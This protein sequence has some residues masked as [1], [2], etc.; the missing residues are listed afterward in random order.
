MNRLGRV[1]A[2]LVAPAVLILACGVDETPTPRPLPTVAERGEALS[3]AKRLE[4]LTYIR[5][6]AESR[7]FVGRGFLWGGIAEAETGLAHCNS[8]VS[9][10][11]P[12]P[13]SADCGGGAVLAGGADGPCG[14]QQG[15]LGMFQFDAGTYAQTVAA[16]SND[17]LTVKGNVGH[18][19]DFV[20]GIV[21]KS[22]Y[23]GVGSGGAIAWL[24]NFDIQNATQR[25]QW[26]KTVTHYYNGCTP[27]GCSVY[28]QRYASYNAALSK[29]INEVGL[30]FWQ[31]PA[32]QPHCQ[33]TTMI[34][35]DCSEGPCGAF[36]ATCAND[37]L[38]LRCVAPGCSAK[39]SSTYCL[40]EKI[41]GTCKDGALSQ[42]DCS[43]FAAK[44]AGAN[45]S[46][47]CES[48]L[49]PKTGVK[50][51]CLDGT[52]L[53][54]CTEGQPEIG[55]CGVFGAICD[56][57]GGGHCVAPYAAKLVEKL[58]DAP[59]DAAKQA[60]YEVCA[61]ASVTTSFELENTGYL[62]W[63]DVGGSAQAPYGQR[64]R[65]ATRVGATKDQPDPLVGVARISV[66][67]TENHEVVFKGTDCADKNGCRRVIF[68][69]EGS[70]PDKPGVYTTGWK[71]IDEGRYEF[72]EPAMVVTYRVKDCPV[73]VE[74][75]DP[76]GTG[77]AGGDGGAG[78]GGAASGA[79]G[80]A[81]GGAAQGGSAGQA[82]SPQGQAG[83]ASGPGASGAAGETGN[84]GR[85]GSSARNTE[86]G[87]VSADEGGCSFHPVPTGDRASSVSATVPFWLGAALALSV[88]TRRRRR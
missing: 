69:L 57:E 39:G 88:A 71:L 9:Y 56:D 48:V 12:G 54:T 17:V 15:G 18:A 63:S 84:A 2:G 30:P 82:G 3:A 62:T 6:V 61:G 28:N 81:G 5:E 51:G 77:G 85:G 68:R 13:T 86:P 72:A 26:I 11:C 4:R 19:I 22:K 70:A 20:I 23:I 29:V 42:G 46:A 58:S 32:C 73:P 35:A 55:D 31:K 47:K 21:G 38:G 33:G 50:K 7:G 79:A 67:S 52:K 65:L 87:F 83:E 43:A 34:A 60:D 75:P 10:G 45:G 14:N 78:V 44:C 24:K 25:D 16:Y 76:P 66:A 49:C 1:V 41:I 8:E 37:D 36:G 53:L 80:N 64:I 40:N 74:P 59:K 27:T